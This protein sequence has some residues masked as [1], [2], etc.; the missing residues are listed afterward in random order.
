MRHIFPILFGLGLFAA[1]PAAQGL[2]VRFYPARQLHA[3]ELDPAQGL[4][5]VV[6][7]NVS[8]LNDGESEVVVSR[9]ELELTEGGVVSETKTLHPSELDRMAAGAS[10]LQEA[11]MF[12]VLAFQFGGPALLPQGV[13][14]ASR[15]TLKPGEALLMTQQVLTF[16]GIREALRIRVETSSGPGNSVIPI[17]TELSRTAFQLPLNG[18]WHDG[19]GPSLHSH[20]RW[21]VPQEFAH[22]FT[23]IGTDGLAY[24]GAG[25]RLSDYYAYGQPVFAAAAGRVLAVLNDEPEDAALLQKPEEPLDAYL[26]RLVRRQNEQLARGARGIV[27]NHVLIGHGE[28]Y[29]LYAHLK[30]GSVRVKAG[31]EV[32]KGQQIASVGSSGSSTE[33]HLHFHVCDAPEVLLCAGIPARF[34]GVEIYGALQARQLQS[35]DLARNRPAGGK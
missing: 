26:K 4:R 18:M 25:Q 34:E 31:D 8:I 5:S 28:E 19:A 32:A 22:D 27:G 2:Q 16:S 23:R 20:H 9:V 24:R 33:P 11:G 7:Q 6:L 10:Q 35:G 30:P 12:K 1:L 21:V 3:Y 13:V 29:S 15:R 17:S 14:V